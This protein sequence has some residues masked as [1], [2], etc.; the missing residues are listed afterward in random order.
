MVNLIWLYPN[1]TNRI[2]FVKNVRF[3]HDNAVITKFTKY[4]W[5]IDWVGGEKFWTRNVG[6]EI[7][8]CSKLILSK[9]K[10]IYIYFWLDNL[11]VQGDL[12]L[13][14]VYLTGDMGEG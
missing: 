3:F 14:R 9:F 2:Q 8:N 11:G 7:L 5:L 4:D 12:L 10:I 13:G 6:H 1:K